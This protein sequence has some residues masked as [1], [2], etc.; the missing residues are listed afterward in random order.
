MLELNP[1]I[2]KILNCYRI[3]PSINTKTL[4]ELSNGHMNETCNVAMGIYSFLSDEIKSGID[5]S[6]LKEASMLHD[7]GKVLIPTKIL[8]KPTNTARIERH[9]RYQ[10][11][12]NAN[13]TLSS[14]IFFKEFLKMSKS[15]IIIQ[16]NIGVSVVLSRKATATDFYH[17]KTKA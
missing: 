5:E 10:T 9:H 13:S 2:K 3:K 4:R 12:N 1:R 6:I 17:F 8:N 11:A 7:L 14:G 15:L 16:K